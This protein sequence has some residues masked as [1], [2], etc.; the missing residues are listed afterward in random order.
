MVTLPK[1][2]K[3]MPT[4]SYKRPKPTDDHQNNAQYIEQPVQDNKSPLNASMYQM[5]MP[6]RDD[7]PVQTDLPL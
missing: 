2:D 3:I 5:M 6:G 7:L 1:N 4:D